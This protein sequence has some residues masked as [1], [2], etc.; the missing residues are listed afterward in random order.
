[1]DSDYI[2]YHI[3]DHTADLGIIV[4]GHDLKSLFENAAKAMIDLMVSGPPGSQKITKDIVIEGQDS[5]DL[6]VRWLGEILYLFSGEKLIVTTIKITSLTSIML[7]CKLTL[8]RFEP[9]RHRV[10]REIKAVTYHQISVERAKQ[11]WVAR[12]IFDI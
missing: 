7:Q 9:G 6:M 5:E 1:M 11:G 3:T 8:T 2:P 12:I 10:R 4:K